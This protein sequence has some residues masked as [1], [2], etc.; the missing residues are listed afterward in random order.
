MRL[1][2]YDSRADGSE[3]ELT[4]HWLAPSRPGRP[5]TR[6]ARQLDAT[7]AVVAEQRGTGLDGL[8]PTN[9]WSGGQLVL[10]RVRL[11]G[12]GEMPVTM[13]IGWAA[14]EGGFEGIELVVDG[15]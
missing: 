14:P 4:L 11:P 6:V 10:D 3:L 5:L 2:G 13:E 7:R 12:A 15:R 1:V 9:E 8:F